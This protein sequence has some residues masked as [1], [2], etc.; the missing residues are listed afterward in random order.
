MAPWV[1]VVILAIVGKIKS[2]DQGNG[3]NIAWKAFPP[4]PAQV[5]PQ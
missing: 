4:L 1:A 3:V 5:T 2:T